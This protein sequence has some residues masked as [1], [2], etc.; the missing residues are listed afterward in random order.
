MS[1]FGSIL[2][3]WDCNWWHGNSIYTE[4]FEM[5]IHFCFSFPTASCNYG[6]HLTDANTGSNFTPGVIPLRHGSKVK[7]WVL[8]H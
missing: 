3:R 1:I 2:Y 8:R 5:L 7:A 6:S 4:I